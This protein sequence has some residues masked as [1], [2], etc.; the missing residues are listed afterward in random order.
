[1]VL[2]SDRSDTMSDED[3]ALKQDLD[4][5][6][7]SAPVKSEQPDIAVQAID[8][9]SGADRDCILLMSDKDSV[10][11]SESDD[12]DQSMTCKNEDRIHEIL[13]PIASFQRQPELQLT[14]RV[15]ELQMGDGLLNDSQSSQ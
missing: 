7:L 14:R 5:E 2:E 12:D 10:G 3:S 1:M 8:T 11:Q 13:S 6:A 15:P 4:E 9:L